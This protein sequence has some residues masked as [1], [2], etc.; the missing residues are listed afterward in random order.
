MATRKLSSL[1]LYTI[2]HVYTFVGLCQIQVERRIFQ[3]HALKF[4]DGA[5]RRVTKESSF[6]QSQTE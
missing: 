2:A 6:M 4:R 3:R 1:N 5:E